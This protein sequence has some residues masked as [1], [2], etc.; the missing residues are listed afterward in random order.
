MKRTLLTIMAALTSQVLMADN[1]ETYNEGDTIQGYFSPEAKQMRDVVIKSTLPKIRV[2]GDALR[3][4][5]AGSTLEKAG[6]TTEMLNKLPQVE[7][8]DNG[9]GVSVYGR[10]E[11]EV[12]INGRKVLDLR[13]LDRIRAEQVQYVDVVQNSGA[14]YAA[15]TK[16]VIRI[17]LKKAQGEG[18]SF[19]ED[20]MGNIQYGATATDYIDV[21]YRNGGFDITGSMW[22]GSYGTEGQKQDNDLLYKCGNDQVV[23]HS[24]QEQNN[25]WKGFSPQLQANYTFGSHE[26]GA[27]QGSV[28]AFYKF[29][30]N[31]YNRNH[32]WL[33]TDTYI[34]DVLTESSESKLAFD[35]NFTRHIMNG[36]FN[37]KA[38]QWGIDFNVDLYFDDNGDDNSTEESTQQHTTRGANTHTLVNNNTTNRN[39]F[40]ATKLILT[41][42]LWKGNLSFGG[43]YS[44]THRTDNYSY[45]ATDGQGTGI[46]LP[47]NT[48]D[49]KINESATAGFIEYGHQFGKLFAQVGLRYEYLKNDYYNFG[50]REEEV[51]RSYG[52][53]FPTAI[54]SM[55]VGKMQMSL[56]YRR[57]IQRPQYSLL[58]N[59]TLYI[60]R[61]TFQSGNPYLKPTYTHSVVYNAAYKNLQLSVMYE[62]IHDANSMITKPFPGAEDP[63]V[64]LILPEN[65]DKTFNQFSISPSYRPTFGLWHPM[66]SAG[67]IFQDYETQRSDGT[68]VKLNH[69]LAQVRWNNDL[70]FPH[71][72]MLSVN[73]QLMTKGDYLS[74]RMGRAALNSNF[75]VRKDIGLGKMGT[76]TCAL[77]IEDPF[78]LNKRESLYFGPRDLTSIN[79]T[80]TS[81]QLNLTWKFNEAS[82]KYRGGGAGSKQKS[83]M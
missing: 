54:L 23:A 14:R 29:D 75:K 69:P 78:C 72:W 74:Y 34:N 53:W 67:I 79:P 12:Y 24:T 44:N 77:E 37:G 19:T 17:Q 82:K 18:F 3:T 76:L 66:W 2:K 60:N 31:Y 4:I 41:Y 43:E 26:E 47:V 65:H 70:T 6:S 30:R 45:T 9:G 36:Y 27:F 35:K 50:V 64:S 57:D 16:A 51:C 28:G 83:R 15:S 52:D 40:V 48:S 68:I 55:P 21:N 8:K 61:Y 11:A 56:S 38:S 22:A 81:Y 73:M 25:R 58:T 1:L 39:D 59:S 20:A 46:S 33:N 63:L 7:A 62:N 32:G 71:D 42:P 5:V 49:S 80:R 13:E 10:G